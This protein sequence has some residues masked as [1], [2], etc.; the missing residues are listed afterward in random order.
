MAYKVLAVANQKG[1]VGKTTTALNLAAALT[2]AGKNTLVLDLDPHACAS[3]HLRLYPE[4]LACTVYDLFHSPEEEVAGVWERAV[5]S[6]EEL[7]F[8]F[9]AG[10]I[11]IAELENDLKDR[12]NKGVMLKRRLTPILAQYDHVLLDCPPHVGIILVNALVAADLL[13]IPIQ[14]DFMALHGVRLLLDTVRTLNRV[15]PRAVAFRGLATM[16]DRRAGGL[17]AGAGVA[18]EQ[19]GRQDVPYRHP[20]G[21]QVPR[22]QRAGQGDLRCRAQEPGR[23]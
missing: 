19:V 11:R 1:G 23:L 16:Y 8:D 7:P 20:G 22:G 9:V 4:H 18:Q 21:Y 12:P 14:T 17:S 6:G 5:L 15:L 2:L 3:M 10:H 13:V